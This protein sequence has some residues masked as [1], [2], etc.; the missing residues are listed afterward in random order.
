MEQPSDTHTIVSSCDECAEL[1]RTIEKLEKINKA[2]VN[3]VERNLDLQGDSFVLFQAAIVME[4]KVRERT[5]ALNQALDELETTN[6]K[7]ETARDAAERAR[8]EMRNAL[9]Q[10]K[11]LSE[12]KTRFVSMASHEFRTP[13]TTIQS[14]AE[15]LTRFASQW[16][17][18]KQHKHLTRI[19]NNVAHMTGLLNEVL[20]LGKIDAGHM[21]CQPQE[22]EAVAYITDLIEELELGGLFDRH[23]LVVDI[24]E[25]EVNLALDP[26]L[27]RMAVTNL[28]TNAVKYSREGTRIVIALAFDNSQ[29]TLEV[30]DAGIGIPAEDLPHLFKPFH[31][32]GNVDSR[33]GTGLGLTILKRAID[34]Q[35]GSISVRST[36][37]MGS[38]F[39]V[40]LPRMC[41][42]EPSGHS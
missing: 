34:I 12:L 30:T 7:L 21:E 27:I 26:S 2:L 1:R 5:A 41:I 19:L 31:R 29:L 38:T 14:S 13:L 16:S 4:T 17:A 42:I 15:L 10:E 37:G 39:T 9:E 3:R 25:C 8:E 18:E 22:L 35:H 6:R 24:P 36:V 40:T 33:P 20:L 28:V 11:E 32:A 23:E